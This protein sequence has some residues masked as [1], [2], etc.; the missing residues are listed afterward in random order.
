WQTP[1]HQAPD[2][3]VVVTFDQAVTVSRIEMD[4]GEFRDD[5]PR[6]LRV[7][8]MDDQH[9]AIPVWEGSTTGLAMLA[10]IEDRARMPIVIHLPPSTRGRQLALTVVEGHPQFSWSIAELRVFGH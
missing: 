10:T 3:E 7:S 9:D 8:V 2:D 5:Y 4:L 1:F 6:K